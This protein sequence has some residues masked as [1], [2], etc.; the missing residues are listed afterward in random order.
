MHVVYFPEQEVCK[1]EE[2]VFPPVAEINQQ[3]LKRVLRD[4]PQFIIHVDGEPGQQVN[5]FK[6]GHAIR[7]QSRNCS[8]TGPE[9]IYFWFSFTRDHVFRLFV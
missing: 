3:P 2:D 8:N 5:K 1:T 7:Q 4:V 9:E 6:F